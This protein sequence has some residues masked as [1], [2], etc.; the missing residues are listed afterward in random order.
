MDTHRRRSSHNSQ[1]AAAVTNAAS[2]SVG[3]HNNDHN[4]LSYESARQ[5]TPSPNGIYSGV[6]LARLAAVG[7]QQQQ[8]L[9]AVAIAAAAAKLPADDDKHHSGI[10]NN[11]SNNNFK[12]KLLYRVYPGIGQR[13]A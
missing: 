2:I 11:F 9:A 5:S 4:N 13:V 12:E 8:H 3:D 7:Q 6:D 10:L 1:S